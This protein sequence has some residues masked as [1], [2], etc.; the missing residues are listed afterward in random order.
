M[1]RARAFPS[2]ARECKF[3]ATRIAV[4]ALA[5]PTYTESLALHSYPPPSSHLPST[6]LSRFRRRRTCNAQG[7][8]ELGPSL[9]HLLFAD[10]PLQVGLDV[11]LARCHRTC[12]PPRRVLDV[13][14]VPAGER[15]CRF[16][17]TYS[18]RFQRPKKAK[19]SSLRMR[20]SSPC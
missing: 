11:L 10:I 17:S 16:L 8:G 7:L 9:H 15:L 6:A 18:D 1:R 3:Y 13:V 5:P 4:G 19:I 20:R 2:V 14:V 12:H